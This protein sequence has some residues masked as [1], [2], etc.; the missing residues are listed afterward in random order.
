MEEEE[1]AA[2]DVMSA[3]SLSGRVVLVIEDHADIRA[4]MVLVLRGL[5]ARVLEAGDGQGGL[6]EL[7]RGHPT[8]V[9]CDLM[10][11][12]MDGFEFARRVRQNRAY[13]HVLL[14]AVTAHDDPNFLDKTWTAG[15]HG[16]L[17]KPVTRDQLTSLARR[18]VG[19]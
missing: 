4:F 1:A 3:P 17:V 7:A 9:L 16:H 11:P 19:E 10:M 12:A 13:H 8:V 5:G 2:D 15:F 18:I 14:I 6:R